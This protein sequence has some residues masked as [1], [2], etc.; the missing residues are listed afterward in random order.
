MGIGRASLELH[1]REGQMSDQKPPAELEGR[2]MDAAFAEEVAGYTVMRDQQAESV[3]SRRPSP[4]EVGAGEEVKPVNEPLAQYSEDLSLAA[5]AVD[6][7]FPK[8]E[9]KSHTKGAS[10]G[11]YQALVW[12]GGSKPR[13]PCKAWAEGP[14]TALCRAAVM[15]ARESVP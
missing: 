5:E 2:A 10:P 12:W 4:G 6:Q 3:I 1:E 8:W 9:L 7:K 15:A 14:A 11:R 13:G